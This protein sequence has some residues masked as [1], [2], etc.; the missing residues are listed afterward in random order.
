MWNW[1]SYAENTTNCGD[2]T[3][4]M[5]AGNETCCFNGEGIKEITYHNTATIPTVAEAWA[6]YY[7]DAGYSVPTTTRDPPTSNF[8]ALNS[9]SISPTSTTMPAQTTQSLNPPQSPSE[10]LD[11][12][13]EPKPT[14]GSTFTTAISPGEKASIGTA[15]AL[16]ALGL[17]GSLYLF[18]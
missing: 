10:Q 15:G 2:G 9:T 8:L 3:F 12:T 7:K 18:R 1:F 5:D 4:C 17:A 11:P 14:P 13:N 6:I 16:G